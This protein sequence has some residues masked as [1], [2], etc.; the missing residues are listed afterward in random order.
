MT[1]LSQLDTSI[2]NNTGQDKNGDKIYGKPEEMKAYIHTK[3]G[4]Q[5][6]ISTAYI[7]KQP[8]LFIFLLS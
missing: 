8:I 6:L 2:E 7:V 3:T 4:I 5:T 1:L